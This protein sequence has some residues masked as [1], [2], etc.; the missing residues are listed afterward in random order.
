LDFDLGNDVPKFGEIILEWDRIHEEGMI[1]SEVRNNWHRFVG[2]EW[3]TCV[4]G[5]DCL[6][7]T[8]DNQAGPTL[9]ILGV[10]S[11]DD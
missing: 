6:Y 11:R 8:S 4:Y 1:F 10:L 7:F 9:G 2:L 3:G 5:S